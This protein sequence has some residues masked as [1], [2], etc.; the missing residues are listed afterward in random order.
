MKSLIPIVFPLHCWGE[1]KPT[2][3]HD[4]HWFNYREKGKIHSRIQL[5]MTGFMSRFYGL[6]SAMETRSAKSRPNYEIEE[7]LITIDCYE[8]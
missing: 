4:Q 8:K 3:G 5:R 1:Y 2:A 7:C 6:L